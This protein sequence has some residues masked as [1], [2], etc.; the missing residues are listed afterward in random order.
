MAI[1]K[2]LID[3]PVDSVDINIIVDLWHSALYGDHAGDVYEAF[4][5]HLSKV[6]IR[7]SECEVHPYYLS[8]PALY[9]VTYDDGSEETMCRDCAE[10]RIEREDC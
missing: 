5:R 7:V 6:G 4:T 8:F 2:R 9:I 10:D 1:T 3:L